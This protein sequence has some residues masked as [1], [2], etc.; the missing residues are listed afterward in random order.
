M[1]KGAFKIV[2]IFLVGAAGGIFASWILNSYS[3]EKPAYL[4][5]NLANISGQSA[6]NASVGASRDLSGTIGKVEKTIIRFQTKSGATGT[7]VIVTSDGLALTLAESIPQGANPVFYIDGGMVNYQIVKRDTKKNLVLIKLDA[8]N[9]QTFSFANFD[10]IKLGQEV[11]LMGFVGTKNNFK[12][13][14]NKGIVRAFDSGIVQTNIIEKSEI[15]GSP[16]FNAAGELLGINFIDSD[17][18]V[19]AISVTELKAFAGL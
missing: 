3:T 7:C 6:A 15:E 10:D 5:Q 8:K 19:S 2:F 16:L 18:K 17:G 13:V 12:E 14:A 11:F 1:L 9:L 4:E